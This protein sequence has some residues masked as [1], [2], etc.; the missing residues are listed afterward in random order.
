V[1]AAITAPTQ[2]PEQN[3]YEV[4]KELKHVIRHTLKE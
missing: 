2:A 3:R 1:Q 4:E